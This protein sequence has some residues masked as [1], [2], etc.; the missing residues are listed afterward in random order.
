MRLRIS[1]KAMCCALKNDGRRPFPN[2]RR[3]SHHNLVHALNNLGWCKL[4]AGSLDELI[5][6]VEQ[7]I[8][9][10]P[11][12]PVIGDSYYL[13]GTVHLL[14]SH[15]DRRSSG[16]KK[17]AAL[18]PVYRPIAAASPPPMPSEAKPNAPPPNSPKP[19]G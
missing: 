2:A 18:S 4:Y 6:L 17:R 11:R 1:S 19:G 10:S 3:R 15:I 5:P 13:I 14:Q 12:D 9:L 8:R 16:S 7:V